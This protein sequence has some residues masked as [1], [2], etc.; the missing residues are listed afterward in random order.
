ME[1][2]L[3]N[4]ES[5]VDLVFESIDKADFISID[6]EFSGYTAHPDDKIND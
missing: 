6:C 3:E 1:I 5:S 4:F 2:T